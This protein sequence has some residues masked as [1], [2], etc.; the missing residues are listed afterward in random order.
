M[1]PGTAAD[2]RCHCREQFPNVIAYVQGVPK[3]FNTSFSPISL[4]IAFEHSG[5]DLIFCKYVT[6]YV[7]ELM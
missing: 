1:F 5:M 4:Y 7:L 6:K 3:V 2:F